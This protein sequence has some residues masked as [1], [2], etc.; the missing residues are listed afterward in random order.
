MGTLT[1][2]ADVVAWVEG[3]APSRLAEPWDNVGLLWGDPASAAEK[4]LTCLTVTAAVA[5]E[6]IE[7]R[8]DVIVSHHPVLF[9]AVKSVRADRPEGATLWRL[10]R[11]NVAIVSPHTAL[12]N[13]LG[14]INDILAGRLGL[15]DVGP[16]RPSPARARFK[17]VVFAPGA[18]RAAII[19][20]AFGAGAGRIGDYEG[21]SY[22]GT[23]VGTFLGK[24]GTNPTVGEAGRRTSV[25]E[26][27]IELPV[28]ADCLAPVL[29]AIRAHHS[30]EE[31]AIDVYPLRSE[32]E[33]AGI[34][35]V[36]RLPAA[37]SLSGFAH[38]VSAALGCPP[39]QV[40]GE[41]GRRIGASRSPAAR[42][43][44]SSAM[45]PAPGPTSC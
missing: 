27:R 45:R 7:D 5:A 43:T 37:E 40:V 15:V 38:R 8:A 35:R 14:G 22:S 29:A 42:G 18:E 16:L 6:A 17:V 2:V 32:P 4:V 9:K 11:A 30:Y 33:G 25:R 39:P 26:R 34:G 36:G 23:G 31:P 13:T 3:F 44:I 12:D 24:E 10:A 21:C 28:M 41:P 20:A 19:E 1:T